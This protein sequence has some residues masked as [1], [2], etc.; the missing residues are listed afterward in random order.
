MPSRSS[1]SYA[2]TAGGKHT[3]N[4]VTP[5]HGHRAPCT[6]ASLEEPASPTQIIEDLVLTQ[7]GAP[8][9]DQDDATAPPES[10]PEPEPTEAAA[11]A[12]AAAA[13]ATAA[14]AGAAERDRRFAAWAFVP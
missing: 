8:A 11:S 5:F 12:A 13:G 14:A 7:V 4:A 6:M 2:G 1:A 3:I 9:P 10:E